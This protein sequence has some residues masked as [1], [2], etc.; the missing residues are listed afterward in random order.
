LH[1]LDLDW[2]V[3][4]PGPGRAWHRGEAR[5]LPDLVFTRMGATSPPAALNSLLQ[6]QALGVPV[7]NDPRA[8]WL[9]RDKVR[10]GMVLAQA[11]LP[12]PPMLI[13]GRHFAPGWIEAQ[14]GP[15]PWVVKRAEG[16]KGEA[17]FL[18][19][20][21]EELVEHTRQAV[22]SE[23]PL[24]VQRFIREASGVDLRVFVAS[25]RVLGSMRRRSAGG[26][27]RSNLHQGGSGEAAEASPEAQRIAL[28]ATET[29][30][31]HVAG[32]DLLESDTGPLLIEVNG[33]PGFAGIE[34]ATGLDVSG[35]V[36]AFLEQA[37]ERG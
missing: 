31:L 23:T 1:P 10:C 18:I 2:A 3:G 25:G 8:L 11:G 16:S 27:F 7:F 15:A 22:E 14:L 17:V 4:L 28:A 29:L 13:P 36:V 20:K 33:S 35:D 26:D 30:G 34:D 6:L 37:V 9:T 12:V 5:D 19:Q 21:E 32:V 24:L